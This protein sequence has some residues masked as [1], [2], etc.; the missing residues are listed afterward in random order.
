MSKNVLI[1]KGSPRKNGNSSVLADQAALGARQ[2][3]ADVSSFRVDEMDIRPCDACDF[4]HDTDGICVIKDDM[5]TL[6]P[7]IQQAD[8]IVIASPIYWFTINAQIKLCIDRWY[9]FQPVKAQVWPGKKIGI[10][11][12]Y[13]DSDPYNSGAV[14]AI[15]TF[16]SMFDYLD[17]E[18]AGIVYGSA[19]DIGDVEKQPELMEKAYQLGEKLV[20]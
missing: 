9:A 4:C 6:Y 19:S 7:K 16:Q 10:I 8:S 2:Q 20:L 14:N 12:T 17:V 5:Q 18:I 13:G 11:L 3:G 15:H 1:L